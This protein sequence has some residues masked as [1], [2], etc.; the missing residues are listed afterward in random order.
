MEKKDFNK[1]PSK[2][3]INKP[4]GEEPT[5][6]RYSKSKFKK[7]AF[8]EQARQDVAE[9]KQTMVTKKR[10]YKIEEKYQFVGNVIRTWHGI[11]AKHSKQKKGYNLVAKGQCVK[12]EEFDNDVLARVS[13]GDGRVGITNLADI[14]RMSFAV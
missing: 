13:T 9:K 5:K 2:R 6:K 11:L 14:K 7:D 4:S 8:E 10:E 12:V 1:K 3:A